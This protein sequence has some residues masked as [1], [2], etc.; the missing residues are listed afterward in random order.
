[1][2]VQNSGLFF[3][4]PKSMFIFQLDACEIATYVYLKMLESRKKYKC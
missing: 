2:I 3:P 1:M 4:V